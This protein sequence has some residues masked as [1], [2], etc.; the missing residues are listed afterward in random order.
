MDSV[1]DMSNDNGMVDEAMDSSSEQP[2][3][4]MVD[5]SDTDSKSQD[6]SKDDLP[7]G[8]KE[9]LG[10]QEKRHQREMRQ[11]RDQLESLHARASMQEQPMQQDSPYSDGHAPSGIDEQIHKAVSYALRHKE[12]E[13]REAEKRANQV[14][15]A[16]KYQELGKHLDN[17][18]DK[19]DD[20]EDVVRGEDA[21][22]TPTM[23][24]AALILPKEGPGSAGEVLYKLGK[25]QDLLRRIAKKS[26]DDQ[27]SEMVKLSHALVNGSDSKGSNVKPLGNIKSNPVTNSAGI[28]EKTSVSD[29]RKRIRNGWK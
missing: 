20:F 2:L 13:E 26:P 10:R 17:M 11:M 16:K 5:S 14:R 15:I 27:A 8:V 6:G 3:D 24:D 21:P 28:T 25:D 1:Q 4:D 22:F 19:Y 23:R 12:M 9:R 29:L 18:S 7:K